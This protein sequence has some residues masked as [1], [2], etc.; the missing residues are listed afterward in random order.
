MAADNQERT[1]ESHWSWVLQETFVW[2]RRDVHLDFPVWQM[3]KIEFLSLRGVRINRQGVFPSWHVVSTCR[4][5]SCKIKKQ[6]A[7]SSALSHKPWVPT[8]AQPHRKLWSKHGAMELSG[9]KA[10]G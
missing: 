9:L 4:N 7:K 2:P 5:P 6:A 10:S 3:R 8:S 1:K